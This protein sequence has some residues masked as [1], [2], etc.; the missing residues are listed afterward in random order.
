MPE[1]LSVFC[2]QCEIHYQW[3]TEMNSGPRAAHM[4]VNISGY[5]LS[6]YPRHFDVDSRL[7]LSNGQFTMLR[8]L[9]IFELLIVTCGAEFFSLFL[10]VGFYLTLN[11]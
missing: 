6:I 1:A 2:N 4:A 7:S 10:N 3:F 5:I 8:S 11:K 9:N